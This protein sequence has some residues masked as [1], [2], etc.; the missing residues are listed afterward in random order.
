M[1]IKLCEENIFVNLGLGKT[2]TMTQEAISKK[3]KIISQ[4]SSKLKILVY[5]KTLLRK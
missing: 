4:I 3:E 5:F 1:T 2:L